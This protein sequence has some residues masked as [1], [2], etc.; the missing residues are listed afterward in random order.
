MDSEAAIQAVVD[1]VEN[2]ANVLNA[3]EAEVV[4]H[5]T[6]NAV[7]VLKQMVVQY[8]SEWHQLKNTEKNGKHIQQ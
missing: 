8:L 7:M 3:V 2:D 5:G 1:V 4:V 6:P